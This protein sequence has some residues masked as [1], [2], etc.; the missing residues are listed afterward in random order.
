M[1]YLLAFF[2]MLALYGSAYSQR[3]R[4]LM[5]FAV[6]STNTELLQQRAWLEAEREGVEARDIWLA[7]F[8]D[9]KKFRRMY[10]YHGVGRA[11]FTLVLIGKDGLEK[12]RLEKAMPAKDLFDF[13]DAMILRQE[14]FNVEGQTGGRNDR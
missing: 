12:L 13:I 2:L 6:D 11:D 3:T 14:E 1:R 7:I 9:P 5:L 8:T 4:R 10:E